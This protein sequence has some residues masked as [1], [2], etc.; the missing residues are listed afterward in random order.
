MPTKNVSAWMSDY[1]Q[2]VPP[3]GKARY[4]GLT[5][6]QVLDS[7]PP[8]RLEGWKARLES[9]RAG[10]FRGITADG[11]V[12]PGLFALRDEGAPTTS[13]LAAVATLLGRLTPAQLKAAKHPIGSIARRHASRG[14]ASGW[15][16]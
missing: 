13:I 14:L 11:Q 5:H 3:M 8:H 12:V 15:M 7:L 9:L 4:F 1:H 2:F 10:P 16:R 6:S